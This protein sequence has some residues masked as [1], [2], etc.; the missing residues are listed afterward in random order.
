[1][2]FKSGLDFVN[3]PEGWG[4]E[5]EE[6]YNTH[7]YHQ[8]SDEYSAGFRYEGMAQQVRVAVRVAVAVANAPQLPQWSPSSEFQRQH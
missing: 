8:P 5:Q 2:S 3:R 7:R 4:K 6:E 1:L